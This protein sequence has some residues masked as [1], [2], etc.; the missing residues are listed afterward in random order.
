MRDLK[1]DEITS[2]FQ[3]LSFLLALASVKYPKNGALMGEG[4]GEGDKMS[5]QSTSV[6][7]LRE[8]W[9]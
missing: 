6:E 8:L 3:L 2:F 4:G 9:T 5:S 7:L 1:F